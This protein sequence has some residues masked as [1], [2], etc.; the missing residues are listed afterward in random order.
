MVQIFVTRIRKSVVGENLP[1]SYLF[2]TNRHAKQNIFHNHYCKDFKVPFIRQQN[3]YPI[4]R[5]FLPNDLPT[6]F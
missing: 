2:A 6:R 3:L 4:M 1:C 5:R